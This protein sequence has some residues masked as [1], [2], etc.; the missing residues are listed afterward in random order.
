M[1]KVTV[2]AE[3][4]AER[5]SALCRKLRHAGLVPAVVYG[6]KIQPQS[7]RLKAEDVAAMVKQ[8]QR[9]VDLTTPAGTQKVF[10]RDIQYDATGDRII[11][12]DFNQVAMDEEL[13]LEVTM[14]ITGKPVG[15]TAEGGVLS[16]FVKTVT[17]RCLPDAIPEKLTADVSGLKLDENLLV[18][19]VKTP[20]GVTIVASPELVVA[21]VRLPV[22]EVTAPAAAEPGP[23]EPEVIGK[24]PAE[25]EEAA[26]GGEE[27]KPAAKAPAK[28]EKAGE[29]KDAEKKK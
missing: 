27:A 28:A 10:I 24:K 21:G 23:A 29:E 25:G 2:S 14:E 1:K 17:V 16:Q 4:R 22:L 5:G 3:A 13:T 19:D 18:R 11:H 8:G 15:V 7:L 6:R 12:I 26:E 9:M 20:A